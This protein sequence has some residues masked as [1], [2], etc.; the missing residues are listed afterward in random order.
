MENNMNL[1]TEADL[2]REILANNI[3]SRQLF[4]KKF[5]LE[6]RTSVEGILFL[7]MG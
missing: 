7:M 2:P 1:T 4:I 6:V 5:W 3:A